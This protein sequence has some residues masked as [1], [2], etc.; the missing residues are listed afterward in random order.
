M[1]LGR[2]RGA[3]LLGR[4]TDAVVRPTSIESTI[5]TT[6]TAATMTTC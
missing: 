5:H 2:R 4:L 1:R 3:I 6:T